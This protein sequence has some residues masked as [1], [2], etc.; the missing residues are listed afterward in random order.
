MKSMVTIR[1]ASGREEQFEMTALPG[2]ENNPEMRIR[3]FLESSSFSLQ[4]DKEVLIIPKDQIEM[5]TVGMDRST[6][7]DGGALK[8]VRQARRISNGES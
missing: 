2:A 7:L 8:G 6:I 3:Q 1:F 5:I 4:T